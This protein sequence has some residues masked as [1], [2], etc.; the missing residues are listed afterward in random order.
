MSDDLTKWIESKTRPQCVLVVDDEELV[1]AAFAATQQA[2]NI[3]MDYA[4]SSDEANELIRTCTYDY[5][6]LDMSLESGGSGME[7]LQ[8]LNTT[9]H[10]TTVMI[11]SGS[12]SLHDI[13]YE[14]N[15]LGVISF[16][17]KP[18]SFT[19]S[20][21]ESVFRKMGLQPTGLRPT[22]MQLDLSTHA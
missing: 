1:R 2:F 4:A 3:R 7:V 18:I 6:F 9:Q 10:D 16:I 8:V 22:K 20:Y 5:V 17:R 13:M 21:V 19:P 12:V 11:M 15:R 14:A